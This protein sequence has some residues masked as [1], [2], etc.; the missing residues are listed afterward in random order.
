VAGD[1]TF[2]PAGIAPRTVRIWIGPAAATRDGPLVFY[3]HGTGSSPSEAAYGL[4]QAVIDEITAAGGIVAAPYSDPAAGTFPWFLT[5]SR[6]RMDDLQVADEVLA[7]ARQS[8]GVDVRRIHAVGMSAGG[9]QTT[10]MSYRRSG[11]LASVVTYSGGLLSAYGAPARQDPS[12][13]FAALI[14]D[15]GAEDVVVISFQ[16]ASEAYW[17]ELA[18]HQHFAAICDHGRGHAIPTDARTSVRDFFAAHPYGAT[19]PYSGGLPATF[20]SYC[21][22]TP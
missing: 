2:A 5:T 17:G 4:G 6:S 9:L 3:W 20:P 22:L 7:C 18:G 8:V 16:Q 11:Y 13:R 10:Q 12:N 14:F 15:G 1:V 21:A 19:S